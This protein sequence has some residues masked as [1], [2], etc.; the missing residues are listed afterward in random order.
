[1]TCEI[2]QHNLVP[3]EIMFKRCAPSRIAL[4]IEALHSMPLGYTA[5]C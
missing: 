5:I 4:H 2:G 1:M 3:L